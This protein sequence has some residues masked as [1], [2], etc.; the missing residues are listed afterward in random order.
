MYTTETFVTDG[1]FTLMR[2]IFFTLLIL[3]IL[4]F[5]LIISR[6]LRGKLLNGFSVVS[7][8]IIL[9]VITVQ[10]TYYDAIIV[11]EIGLGG[12]P[13]TFFLALINLGISILNPMLFFWLNSKTEQEIAKS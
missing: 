12:D 2:P 10:V 1:V 6:K 9:G 3:S 13:T 8:S 4:L 11:D 7:L 5:I